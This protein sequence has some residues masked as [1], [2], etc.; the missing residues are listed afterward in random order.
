MNQT[1]WQYPR[2]PRPAGKIKEEQQ[3]KFAIEKIAR[4]WMEFDSTAAQ[5][6]L[7]QTALPEERKASLLKNH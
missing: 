4:Q 3:R 6:W 1:A 2:L 7:A 5:T